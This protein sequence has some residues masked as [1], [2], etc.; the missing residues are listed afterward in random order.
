MVGEVGSGADG[1]LAGAGTSHTE[2]A[3]AEVDVLMAKHFPNLFF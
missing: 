1:L 2:A 3:D